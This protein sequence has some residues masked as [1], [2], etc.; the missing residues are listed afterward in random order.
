MPVTLTESAATR[1]HS[2]LQSKGEGEGLRVGVKTS[3]CS[4]Y[5]YELDYAM[6]INDNDSVFESHGVKVVV[7]SK[8]LEFLEGLEV[9]YVEN[10]L[11]SAFQFRNPNVTDSCGCGESFTTS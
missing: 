5:A 2:H 7:Q 10:G 3:G 11:S 8:H 1:V 6:E 9:D 4:G